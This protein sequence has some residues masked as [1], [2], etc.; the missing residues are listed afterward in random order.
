MFF[1]SSLLCIFIL[2]MLCHNMKLRTK[3]QK[4][5]KWTKLNDATLHKNGIEQRYF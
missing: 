4:D 3:L 1:V 5:T 2:T